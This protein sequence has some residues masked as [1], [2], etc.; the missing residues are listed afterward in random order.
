MQFTIQGSCDFNP[1]FPLATAGYTVQ[2]TSATIKLDFGRGNLVNL[3]AGGI[4]WRTLD[5]ICVSHIHPDHIADLFQ[6]FQAYELEQQ[7]K[8]IAKE[9][10][11]YG[12]RG[13]ADYFDHFRRVISA[14]WPVIPMVQEVFDEQFAIGD[15]QVSTAPMRHHADDVAYRL[16]ADG[17]TVVYTG[18]TGPNDQLAEIARD[19]DVLVVECYFTNN[20]PLAEF[21]MRPTDIAAVAR[22]ARVKKVILTHMAG[23]QA[24]RTQ[25]AQELQKEF[26]GEV[27]IAQDL[28]S[29]EI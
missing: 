11:L 22:A 12:P 7:A 13:F 8:R 4:D 1:D 28:M 10:V 18:D 9:V 5:A 16:E 6:Y 26:R 29:I 15:V 25:R 27:V 23:D 17:A 21:H 2:T 20:D 19:V 3:A 14:P 24:G